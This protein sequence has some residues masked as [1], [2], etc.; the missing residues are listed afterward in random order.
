LSL[1]ENVE[2]VKEELN[3]E[4]KFFESA[5]KAEHFVKKYKTLLISGVVVLVLGVG[6][7]MAYDANVRSTIENANRALSTLQTDP[8]DKSAQTELK[9]LNP[10]L[11]DAWQLSV[12][13]EEQNSEKLA[14]LSASKAIGVSD[15]AAYQKAVYDKDIKALEDY[16]MK[17]EAIY[18]D[19]ALFELA[20]LLIRENKPQEAHS[21]LQ[22]ITEDSPIY[23]YA[24]PL[25]HYGVK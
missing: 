7:K 15:I 13:L 2:M 20:V 25:M 10:D 17:P 12:A 19:M 9:R 11:Y 4:E 22:S 1:K 8:T 21:K 24:K 14:S 6:A 5:V 18:K 16:S 23:R 3:S